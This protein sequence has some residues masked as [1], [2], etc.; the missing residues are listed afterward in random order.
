[1][2]KS[3]RAFLR[4]F[5]AAAVGAS[6]AGVAGL[7]RAFDGPLPAER[8]LGVSRYVVVRERMTPLGELPDGTK[9]FRL[10]LQI[11]YEARYP[12]SPQ[13]AG[14]GGA[15]LHRSQTGVYTVEA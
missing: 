11:E 1:M 13:E 6:V 8:P 10:D 5:A 4:R 9:A 2:S 3:R 14:H 7:A 15:T 12:V